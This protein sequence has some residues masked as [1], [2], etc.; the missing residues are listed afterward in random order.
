MLFLIHSVFRIAL[1]LSK[2]SGSKQ[3]RI[4]KKCRQWLCNNLFEHN[5]NTFLGG[6]RNEQS[7]FGGGV[8]SVLAVAV[9]SAVVV[10]TVVEGGGVVD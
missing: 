8:V 7:T 10:M 4:C 5:S 2:S 9:L 3:T 6:L 1:I